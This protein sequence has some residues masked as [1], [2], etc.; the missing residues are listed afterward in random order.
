MTSNFYVD[1]F[2]RDTAFRSKYFCD[3]YRGEQCINQLIKVFATM[4]WAE[5][6]YTKEDEEE[7]KRIAEEKQ[8]KYRKQQGFQALAKQRRILATKGLY[9]PEEGEVLE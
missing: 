3:V 7:C 6:C 9:E 2:G 1:E 5:I 4:S 8:R